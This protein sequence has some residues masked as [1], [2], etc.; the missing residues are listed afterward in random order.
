MDE[1]SRVLVTY[2]GMIL[3][4][5]PET[6]SFLCAVNVANFPFD[7][8]N[9]TLSFTNLADSLDLVKLKPLTKLIR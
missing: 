1:F 3:Y 4:E 5:T 9:C 7:K 2:N 6:F 8:Q